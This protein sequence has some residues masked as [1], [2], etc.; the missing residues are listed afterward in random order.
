MKWIN[1]TESVNP[2]FNL[3]MEEY[4]LKNRMDDVFLLWQNDNTIVIGRNQNT[5][6]E[7]NL[8]YVKEQNITVARRMSGGGAVYHDLGN[9]NFSFAVQNNEKQYFD[10]AKFA[11]PV[12]ALLNELGVKAELSG[13]NDILVDGK[14]ISGN[15]QYAYHDR[16]LHHG[17]LLFSSNLSKIGSALRVSEQKIESKGIKSVKSRVANISDFLPEK[18]SVGEFRERFLSFMRVQYPEMEEHQFTKEERQEIEKLCREKYST[19]EW[20]FGYSPQYTYQKTKKF[21]SG[22]VSAELDVSDNGVIR[23]AKFYG[24]YFSKKDVSEVEERLRGVIHREEAVREAFK[25]ISMQDY[26]FGISLDEILSL[27]F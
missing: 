10:F 1:Q 18:I 6:Q 25:K 5:L 23:S 4:I 19:W 17:T 22:L 21:P 8:D 20:N 2:H 16:I 9:L 12:I 13:R 7:I 26:F 3:A 27:L 14:K 24:D 15:A 11:A